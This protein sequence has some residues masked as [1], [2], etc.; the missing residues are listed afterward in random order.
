MSVAGRTL[1]TDARVSAVPG[2]TRQPG[3]VREPFLRPN[4]LTSAHDNL[5]TRRSGVASREGYHAPARSANG[6]SQ[7]V[8]LAEWLSTTVE[9]CAE[10][11]SGFSIGPSWTIEWPTIRQSQ[12]ADA[13]N[14][15]RRTRTA[16]KRR[17]SERYRRRVRSRVKS[18][19][20][21]YE[22]VSRN[23][24]RINPS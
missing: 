10:L 17:P 8:P 19:E 23:R 1:Q 14:P 21:V 6:T 7:L 20:V 16:Q 11:A 9:N 13:V 3:C 12:R 5:R 15:G 22:V 4:R 24:P 18:R 2:L